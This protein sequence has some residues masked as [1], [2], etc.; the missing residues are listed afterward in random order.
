MKQKNRNPEMFDS[1][2]VRLIEAIVRQAAKDYLR[3]AKCRNS[4]RRAARMRE[5]AGFF[6]SDYFRRLTGTDGEKILKRI[7]KEAL[8]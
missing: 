3:A 8:K 2:C 6:R 5:A 7:R 4:R 1:G